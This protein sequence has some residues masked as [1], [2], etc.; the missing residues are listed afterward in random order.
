MKKKRERINEDDENVEMIDINE[1]KKEEIVN[2]EFVFSCVKEDYFLMIKNLIRNNFQF[3]DVSI[4]GLAD[5][6]IKMR[7]DIGT[8]I[9]VDNDEEDKILGVFTLIPFKFYK[10]NPVVNQILEMLNNKFD[11]KKKNKKLIKKIINNSSLGLLINERLINLP[12]E[13]VSPAMKLIYKELEE[14]I[15]EEGYNGKFDIDYYIVFS[16]YVHNI[17]DDK[18]NSQFNS[19]NF[20][21]YKYESPLFINESV[22]NINYKIKYNEHGMDIENKNQPQY[23]NV[24]FVKKDIFLQII[25]NLS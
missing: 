22:I 7:E 25:N 17:D 1:G 9:K 11:E 18:K 5:L 13:L 19:D 21:Y 12:Q 14:C 6:I 2:I 24:S 16:K 10:N 3:E 8:T 23:M 15:N 20:L 4:N